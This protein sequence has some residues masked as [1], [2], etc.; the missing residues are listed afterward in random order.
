MVQHKSY[1]NLN[2]KTYLLEAD[3]NIVLLRYSMNH[4]DHADYHGHLR[5]PA[6]VALLE[7]LQYL[8][9]QVNTD[10]VSGLELANGAF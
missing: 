1:A 5:V 7:R 6:T 3:S 9:V 10:I 8:Q 2:C 4:A